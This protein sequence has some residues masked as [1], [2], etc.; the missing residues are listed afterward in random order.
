MSILVMVLLVAS[1]V[2]GAGA[3]GAMVVRKEPF[4]G[5]IGLVTICLPS[6]LLAFAYMAVA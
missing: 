5:V 2:F 4:Y 6:T 3:L 1:V